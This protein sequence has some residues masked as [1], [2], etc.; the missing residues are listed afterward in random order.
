MSLKRF[1]LVFFELWNYRFAAQ[2][3]LSQCN[4]YLAFFAGALR[5]VVFEV[6]VADSA[7]PVASK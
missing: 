1:F 4:R 3:T 2:G 7:F 5:F 6:V